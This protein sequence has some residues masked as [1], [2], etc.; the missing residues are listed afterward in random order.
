MVALVDGDNDRNL[1]GLGVIQGFHGLRLHAV[2]RSDHQ[3]DDVRHVGTAG[4]HGAEGGVTGGV[5]ESEFE[6]FLFPLRVG[7]TDGVSTDVLRDAA[8]LALDHVGVADGVEEG[9]LA[10]VDVTH[11]GDH[12]RTRLKVFILVL[13]IELDLLLD[14]ADA[15]A[16]GAFLQFKLE[17]V[18]GRKLLGNRLVD[19]LIDVRENAQG[20][21]VG[22][23]LEWFAIHLLGQ[24]ADYDR[25]FHDHRLGI[26]GDGKLGLGL[27][28]GGR[29]LSGSGF[30]LG[31]LLFFL[32]SRTTRLEAGQ[33]DAAYQFA[34][35]GFRFGFRLRFRRCLFD[36]G[37][38]NVGGLFRDFGRLFFRYRCLCGFGDH[39]FFGRLL[40][41][42]FFRFRRGFGLL[43]LDDLDDR[44]FRLRSFLFGGFL[45][46]LVQP[47]LLLDLQFEILR[48]DLVEGA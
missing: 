9:G 41:F 36:F 23:E 10:V 24:V 37:F 2:V 47:E 18:L 48:G 27:L 40:G 33:I 4:A 22:D 11:D 20:H 8:G 14:R 26:L 17:S 1:G 46:L 32:T 5:E 21:E 29:L 3:D 30:L 25:R 31:S 45:L 13:D 42:R 6:N 28:L 39:R 44:F 16:F 35:V 34:D 38:G 7:E 19:G 12:G 15:F 43:L